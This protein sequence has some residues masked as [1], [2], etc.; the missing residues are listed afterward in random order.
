MNVF[1]MN[2]K[3]LLEITENSF[4]YVFYFEL[5]A[6]TITLI[7]MSLVDSSES[8]RILFLELLVT[9]ISS[10]MYYLFITDIS[11]YFDKNENPDLTSIDRLR[12]KGWAFTTPLMLISLC[13]LLNETTKIALP[14]FFLFT[15]LV[16]DY[17]MLLI[18]FLGEI[19]VIDRISAM[20]LGFLPFFMIFYL[21]YST[22]L[23]R[24]TTGFNYLVFGIYFFVWAGYGVSYLFDEEIKN[25]LMNIFDCISKGVIA[26]LISGKLIFY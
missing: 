7:S 16:L 10:I 20:I 19:N 6:F 11:K 2:Q 14:T 1:Y 23:V 26:I 15:I 5:F 22:F 13:L 12:Y 24:K 17:V 25:I 3:E 18:G 21:I 4:F 8:R 9:M